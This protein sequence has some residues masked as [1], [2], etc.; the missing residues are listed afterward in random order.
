M[1]TRV[2]PDSPYPLTLI[3]LTNDQR[4]LVSYTTLISLSYSAARRICVAR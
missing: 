4:M 1:G 3:P 2:R